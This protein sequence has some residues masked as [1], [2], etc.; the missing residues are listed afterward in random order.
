MAMYCLVIKVPFVATDDIAARQHAKNV[1]GTIGLIQ[2]P[3]IYIIKKLQETF[4]DQPPRPVSLESS[5]ECAPTGEP[6]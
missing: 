2:G 6:A 5:T 4:P 3:E 1:L